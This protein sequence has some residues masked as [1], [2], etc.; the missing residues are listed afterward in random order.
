[1]KKKFHHYSQKRGLLIVIILVSFGFAFCQVAA[2]GIVVQNAS[3]LPAG[4]GASITSI[5]IIPSPLYVGD[6]VYH[7]VTV[8]NS[9]QTSLNYIIEVYRGSTYLDG[10]LDELIVEPGNSRT[11][12]WDSSAYENPGTVTFTY[13]L[14]YDAPWPDPNVLLDTETK[15]VTVLEKT[16]TPPTTASISVSS[17][18]SGSSVY[19]DGTYKG[20]T[21]LTIPSV[22]Y[23]SHTLKLTRSGYQDQSTVVTVSASSNS[24]AIILTPAPTP[25]PAPTAHIS[26][27]N[28]AITP[29]SNLVSGETSVRSTFTVNF[30]PSGGETFPDS[31]NLQ[32]ASEMDSPSWT[33]AIILDGIENPSKTEIGQNININGWLLSYPSNRE[34]SIKVTMEAKAP[35]VQ[36]TQEK[37][38]LAVRELDNQGTTISGSEVVKTK[39]VEPKSTTTIS[40]SSSPPGASVYLDDSYEGTTPITIPSISY[41]THT[42]KLTLTGYQEKSETITISDSTRSF[43]YNLPKITTSTQTIPPTISKFYSNIKISSTPSGAVVN[44][45]GIFRGFTPLTINDVQFGSHNL[46]LSL[47]GYQDYY[48]SITVT[49][50][51]WIF[52]PYTLV[53]SPSTPTP[54]PPSSFPLEIIGIAVIALIILLYFVSKRRKGDDS[55]PLPTT[56]GGNEPLQEPESLINISPEITTTQTTSQQKEELFEPPQKPELIGQFPNLLLSKYEPLEFIGEGGFAKVYKVSRKSDGQIVA[57]K[58]PRIEE[59]TSGLFLKEVATWYHLNHPNIV[60]LY[61]AELLPI[62]YIEMEYV[63]GKIQNGKIVH[64]FD[65]LSKPFDEKTAI[66]IIRQVTSALK[67]AHS[68]DV[69]HHDIKPLNILTKENLEPKISDFG[70][71]RIGAR[72]SLSTHK[73]Y[74]PL[75]AAPEQLDSSLYGKPDSRTDTYQ[76]GV[77]F[78]ELLTG[79]MPFEASSP[80]A[81]VGKIMAQDALHIPVSKMNSD[82]LK[83]DGIFDRLLAKRKE[84]RY[85]S[86]NEFLTA[87]E[88]I[89]RIDLIKSELKESLENTKSVLKKS[90]KKDEVIH[91][92][93]ETLFKTNKLAILYAQTNDKPGVIKMLEELKFH[94]K[95]NLEELLSAIAHLE[96]MIAENISI[97]PQFMDNLQILLNRI[98]KE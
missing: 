19:L 71:A 83:Y 42:L 88:S 22:S 7:Q 17:T 4:F 58:I 21:P 51:S 72:S 96:V 28:I 79:K 69:Y 47:S 70:L 54:L 23:G 36:S 76:V 55:T 63:E 49:E 34:L 14:Y 10:N 5:N 15:S 41:G 31:H 60:R 64:D 6:H 62:P 90:T 65:K 78:Y 16:A 59:K 24:F 56:P 53:P 91:L 8:K 50:G 68:K 40:V 20:T 82:Y 95:E 87:L 37:I 38:V 89:D 85:Q 57:I 45:D 81:L 46:K 25:T 73:G 3:I 52:G 33:Y 44:L 12:T 75:Y 32:L 94:T 13:K 97:S 2:D 74:S 26:V 80:A 77:V 61:S 18:P 39:I 30:I 43:S 84:D 11:E 9:G 35:V 92:K 86:L 98:E 27:G 66:Q 29:S 1:M 48:T 67:Y 93:R